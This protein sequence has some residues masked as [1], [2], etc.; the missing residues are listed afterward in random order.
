[1]NSTEKTTRAGAQMSTRPKFPSTLGGLYM[2]AIQ[3]SICSK[4]PNQQHDFKIQEKPEE[5]RATKF[6]LQRCSFCGQTIITEQ[7]EE[8]RVVIS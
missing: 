7:P 5:L 1:M 6:E 3:E 8:I 4:A 2:A